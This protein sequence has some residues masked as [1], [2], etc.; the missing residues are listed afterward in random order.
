MQGCGVDAMTAGLPS[1]QVPAVPGNCV[2]QGRP[3][4]RGLLAAVSAHHAERQGVLGRQQG[5]QPKCAMA[6]AADQVRCDPTS[7]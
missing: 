2:M 1:E 5:V 3:P 4:A 6:V 7:H